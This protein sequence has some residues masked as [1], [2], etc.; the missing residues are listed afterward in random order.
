M[1]RGWF[2]RHDPTKQFANVEIKS[3]AQK[4]LVGL[5]SGGLFVGLHALSIQLFRQHQDLISYAFLVIVPWFAIAASLSKAESSP[6][7]ARVSWLLI[8]VAFAVWDVGMASAA[9]A[10]LV[11]RASPL[12]AGAADFFYFFYGAVVVAAMTLSDERD[13]SRRTLIPDIIQTALLGFLV[14]ISIFNV[15]PLS[16]IKPQ[17]ID[18]SLLVRT[19]NIEN[20]ALLFIAILRAAGRSSQREWRQFDRIVVLFLAIYGLTAYIYN[21]LVASINFSSCYLDPIVDIPFLAFTI[22]ALNQTKD[23]A[24]GSSR[25]SHRALLIDAMGPPLFTLCVLVLALRVAKAHPYVG[26]ASM[27]I[28]LLTYTF[29]SALWQSRYLEIQTALREA[30]DRLELLYLQDGLTGVSNRRAFDAS[31]NVFWRRALDSRGLLSLLLIDVDHFKKLNDTYGHLAGD[32]CLVAVAAVLGEIV[33]RKSD[34]IS[35]YGGEEFAVLLPDTDQN[36]AIKIARQI[37]AK[38]RNLSIPNQETIEKYLTVSVGVATNIG[39]IADSASL[40]NSADIALYKAKRSGR[41]T[42]EV[43]D[44]PRPCDL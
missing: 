17:P 5:V 35:R 33:S 30:H 4:I 6:E 3:D 44:E 22:L 8:A 10:D 32:K 9:W 15:I 16:E 2:A 39:Q 41:N 19:Y 27:V 40:L 28:S 36:S 29:R 14:Y 24:Q 12:V 20:L 23:R 18:A 13:L 31:L 25:K 37:C 21:G 7:P 42:V 34:L 1:M 38:V 11:Q 43:F 26:V